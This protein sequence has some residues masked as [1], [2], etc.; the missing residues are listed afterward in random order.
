MSKK[1][2]LKDSKGLVKAVTSDTLQ[3]EKP[4]ANE[5]YDI[6]VHNR[7]M[8]KIDKGVNDAKGLA[9]SKAPK[10]HTHNMDDIEGLSLEASSVNYDNSNSK[11]TSTKAQGA[12]DEV[13]TKAEANK[14]SIQG[15]K[16]DIQAIQN[17]MGTNRSEIIITNNEIVDIFV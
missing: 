15:A 2:Y 9:E 6:N 17:E 4:L 1:K 13:N 10:N 3:L 16:D 5:N 11:L 7:N 12:I 8:D 14:T